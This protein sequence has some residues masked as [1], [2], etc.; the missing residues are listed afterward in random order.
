MSCVAAVSL[1]TTCLRLLRA[2]PLTSLQ[3]S[4]KTVC[5]RWERSVWYRHVLLL[6][7]LAQAPYHRMLLQLIP[8]CL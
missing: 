2:S 3:M 6:P 7:D 8:I 1:A 4:L 5:V